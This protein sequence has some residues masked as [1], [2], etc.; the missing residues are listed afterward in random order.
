MACGAVGHHGEDRSCILEHGAKKGKL[1][2]PSPERYSIVFLQM[3]DLIARVNGADGAVRVAPGMGDGHGIGRI[4]LRGPSIRVVLRTTF[5]IDIFPAPF[6]DPDHSV[7]VRG[8]LFRMIRCVWALG[9]RWWQRI[10]RRKHMSQALP[11]IWLIIPDRRG[12]ENGRSDGDSGSSNGS[13]IASYVGYL[14]HAWVR[15]HEVLAIIGLIHENIIG[16]VTSK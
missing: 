12:H 11:W 1:D 8:P 9:V 5:I 2:I 7:F 6:L 4:D 10:G 16:E 15:Q 3:P 13:S 14:I